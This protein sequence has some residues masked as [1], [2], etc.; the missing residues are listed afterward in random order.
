M[1]KWL[2]KCFS[3]SFQFDIFV[4][5]IS[6]ATVY[7]LRC[8]ST[9]V[10]YLH[11]PDVSSKMTESTCSDIFLYFSFIKTILILSYNQ[12]FPA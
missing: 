6:K 5:K 9:N 11:R 3:F 8:S 7:L 12:I 1:R 10:S 4:Y 2:L